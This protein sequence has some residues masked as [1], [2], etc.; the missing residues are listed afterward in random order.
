MMMV[1]WWWHRD[2]GT[3]IWNPWPVWWMRSR[4][5]PGAEQSISDTDSD[6][7]NIWLAGNRSERHTSQTRRSARSGCLWD[8]NM[9]WLPVF[10]KNE[11]GASKHWRPQI[12]HFMF[13]WVL[14]YSR[15]PKLGVSSILNKS[16]KDTSLA[17]LR[18]KALSSCKGTSG[19]RGIHQGASVAN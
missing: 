14:F 3:R 5:C 9:T 11:L 13:W 4:T 1:H 18:F 12:H 8:M 19:E 10:L 6:T 17:L 7:L 2:R 15:K 16:M